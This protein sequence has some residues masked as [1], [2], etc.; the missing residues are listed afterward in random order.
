MNETNEVEEHYATEELGEDTAQKKTVQAPQ[1]KESKRKD[2]K[3]EAHKT[4]HTIWHAS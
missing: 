1:K 4:P 2:A 3:N